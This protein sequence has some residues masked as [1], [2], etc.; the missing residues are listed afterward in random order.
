MQ[1]SIKNERDTL[2]VTGVAKEHESQGLK[3]EKRE[4][5]E[6]IAKANMEIVEGKLVKKIELD[7]NQGLQLS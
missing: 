4:M 5:D 7:N 1:A 3:N 2:L 6:M